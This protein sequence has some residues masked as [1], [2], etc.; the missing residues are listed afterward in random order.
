MHHMRHRQCCLSGFEQRLADTHDSIS[1]QRFGR[2]PQLLVVALGL[3]DAL[4]IDAA[5]KVAVA[6]GAQRL[7]PPRHKLGPQHVVK[8]PK[9]VMRV[10]RLLVLERRRERPRKIQQIHPSVRPRVALQ[11]HARRNL[12]LA[13]ARPSVHCPV[14][15]QV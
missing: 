14:R 8:R 2:R 9:V 13:P 3:L 10:A 12:N 1:S 4:L 15:L 6:V 11:I 5:Q 7:F